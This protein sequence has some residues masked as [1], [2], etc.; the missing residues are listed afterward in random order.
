MSQTTTTAR[1]L[2]V[3]RVDEQLKGLESRL[4]AAERFLKDQDGQ[5]DQIGRKHLTLESQLRQLRATIANTESEIR[6]FDERLEALRA[7]MNSAQTNR[8]YKALLA[9]LNTIKADRDRIETAG[10]EHMTKADAIAKEI[11]DLG[12]KRQERERVRVVAAGERDNRAG[13][14]RAR[15]EELRAQ[16]V[17]LAAEV[18]PEAMRVYQDLRA[19]RGDEEE[20]MAAVEVADLKRHEFTCGGCMKSLPLE[21]VSALLSRGALTRC[22][23]CGLILYLTEDTVE[24]MSA[25]QRK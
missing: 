16:R 19:T 23:S 7:K 15:V 1:L 24:G 10:L 25:Q 4:R 17:A 20:V 8:E 3:F 12:G 9:E 13:E 6:G 2:R 14:I 21:A 18:P 5:L 22:R 11:G